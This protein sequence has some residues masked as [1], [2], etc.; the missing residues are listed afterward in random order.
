MKEEALQPT[1]KRLGRPTAIPKGYC[2]TCGK[3]LGTT[4]GFCE[5][6]WRWEHKSHLSSQMHGNIDEVRSR[7]EP[8]TLTSYQNNLWSTE[9]I[10]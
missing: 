8:V 4:V 5:I 2:P 7:K 10:L 3:P 1:F 6:D 9:K